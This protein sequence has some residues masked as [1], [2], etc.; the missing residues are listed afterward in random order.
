MIT[1]YRIAVRTLLKKPLAA[2]SFFDG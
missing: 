1:Y 2:R